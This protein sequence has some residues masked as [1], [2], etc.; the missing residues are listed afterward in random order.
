VT[1]EDGA[2]TGTA[3]WTDAAWRAAALTWAEFELDCLRIAMRGEPEQP[4][5]MPWSTVLRLDVD[6]GPVWLKSIGS[7]SAQEP[8]LSSALAGWVPGRVLAP[9]AMHAGRRLTLLPDGGPTLRDTGRAAVPESWEAMLAEYAQ[10]QLDLAPYA[11]EMVAL[12]VPDARPER[13]PALVAELLAD[14][15]AML[16]D[17]PDGLT[18]AIRER[19]AADLPTYAEC[20]RRLAESG[21]PASLQHD[22]L[23]DGNVFAGADGHRFFDWGDATVSH[24]FLSLLVSLRMAARALDVPPGDPVLRRLRDAY[25]EPWGSYGSRSELR[26]LCGVALRVG[27]PARAL[28]WHRILVGI[29]PGERAEWAA[30]VPGWMAT[31][32]EPGSLGESGFSSR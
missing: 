16:L 14:D 3:T 31:Y 21:V 28:T 10:L 1:S 4:H 13:L 19:I 7:G 23:H 6:G 9:L 18:T 5:V 20:C 32:L 22:D 12:G 15:E 30:S 11:D 25:L 17:R 27:P 8:P 29:H 26:E 24:P 2:L